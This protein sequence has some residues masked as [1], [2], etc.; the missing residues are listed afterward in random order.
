MN[1]MILVF[2]LLNDVQGATHMS[3]ILLVQK[4]L[5]NTLSVRW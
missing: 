3:K 5:S 1:E 2:S 4:S